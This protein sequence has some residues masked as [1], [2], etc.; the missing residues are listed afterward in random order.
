MYC[1]C[2]KPQPV[3]D[4]R[5]NRYVSGGELIEEELVWC[6]CETCKGLI[7]EPQDDDIPF[8]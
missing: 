5:M 8:A 3:E 2:Q 4:S 7:E 6:Y 1:D